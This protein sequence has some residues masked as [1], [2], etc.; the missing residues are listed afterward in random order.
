MGSSLA[1]TLKEGPVRCA[2]VCNKSWVILM[3]L[4]FIAIYDVPWPSMVFHVPPWC[5]MALNGIPWP[6]MGLNSIP[7][8]S[9]VYYGPLCPSMLSKT[10]NGV[11]WPSMALNVVSWSSIA[12]NGFPWRSMVFWAFIVF[13]G[14]QQCSMALNGVP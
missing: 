2:K 11:Q 3:T 6:S 13:H 5:F 10:L 4:H 1:F 9:M 7:W 14:P 12:L 8:P